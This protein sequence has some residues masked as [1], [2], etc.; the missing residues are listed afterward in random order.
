MSKEEAPQDVIEAYRKSQ[1]RS[2]RTPWIFALAALLVI[3]GIAALIFWLTGSGESN[4]SV[5]SLFA[6]KTPV[7]SATAT[8]T[9]EPPTPTPTNTATQAPP[10]NTP[11][12]TLEPTRDG[13]VIYVVEEGDSFYSIGLK[14]EVDL[15]VLI[16]VNR[17]RLELD[18]NNPIIKVGDEILVPPPG[19]ELPTPTILP[20]DLPAGTIVEYYVKSGDT[21][22]G[23]AFRFNSTA[24]DIIKRNEDLADNPN[25]IFVGQLLIIRVNLVTAIPTELP[26]EET[27]TPTPTP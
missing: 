17:E 1:A 23:I 20:A 14:F 16:D 15:D 7:P 13:P 24:E 5:A 18:P 10:T 6:T 12:P 27:A 4:F 22:D 25:N 9:P 11:E 26:V 2:Q 8:P 19:A 21:L 3:A